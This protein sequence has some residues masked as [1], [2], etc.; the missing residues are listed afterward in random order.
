MGVD[1][2]A[3]EVAEPEDALY[4]ALPGLKESLEINVEL[5]APDQFI[6]PVPG[7]EKRS[8]RHEMMHQCRSTQSKFLRV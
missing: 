5:A 8:A 4:R 2:P 1:V 3:S 6:P 7:W